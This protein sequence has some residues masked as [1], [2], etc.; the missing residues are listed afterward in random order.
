ML[1][2]D[3]DPREDI[4]ILRRPRWVIQRGEAHNRSALKE[5]VD[6]LRER[7]VAA[8]L[9]ASLPLEVLP[10]ETPDGVTLLSGL[11]ESEAYGERISSERYAVIELPADAGTAYCS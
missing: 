11:I 5:R 3:S 9:A 1:V 2:V 10:P 4:S 7:Q 6:S 8:A